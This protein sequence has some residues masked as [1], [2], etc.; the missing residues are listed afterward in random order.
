MTKGSA[1]R[2]CHRLGPA[3]RSR[4]SSVRMIGLPAHVPGDPADAFRP[5]PCDRHPGRRRR[6][7][8]SS[9]RLSGSST[10]P[11][12]PSTGRRQPPGAEVF[13]RGDTSGVPRET[14]ELDRADQGRPQGPAR[15]AGRLR[16][17]ERQRH[18]AQALRDVRQRPAGPRAAG[19]ARPATRARASTWSSSARTSRTC[20][21]ASSTC[22][23]PDVGQCLKVITR[24][25]SEKVIR[26]A[27]E[28]ARREGR[29]QGHLRHQGEHHEA[30]RGAV[31]GA[32]SR[33]W[34]RSTRGS[35]R[36]T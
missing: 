29:A 11:A 13:K 18:A 24:K 36:S 31:Q 32:S 8:R 25:G 12:S 30:D 17:E 6:A 26:Y 9:A 35:R 23:T 21:R 2:R 1:A 19:R 14:R 3:T 33:S 20:T 16:R 10:P 15:D 4:A 7:R 5:A 22:V 34:R 28:L 27:F